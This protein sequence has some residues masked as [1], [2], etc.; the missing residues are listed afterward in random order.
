MHLSLLLT[1]WISEIV[2]VAVVVVSHPFH[3]HHHHD[4]F[5]R[6]TTDGSLDE[7]D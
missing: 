6:E 2:V 3:V 7:L 4:F 5:D 1:M